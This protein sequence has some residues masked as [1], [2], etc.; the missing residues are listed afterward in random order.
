MTPLNL[1]NV[2]HWF[3][4]FL[5]ELLYDR[6]MY[7]KGKKESEYSESGVYS[8]GAQGEEQ[9]RQNEAHSEASAQQRRT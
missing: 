4:V 9:D 8:R 6:C 5:Q 1:Y 2:D 3:S 7:A